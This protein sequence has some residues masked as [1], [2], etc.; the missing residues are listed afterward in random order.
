MVINTVEDSPWLINDAPW[1]VVDA[2]VA[3]HKAPVP[4]RHA[5]SPQRYADRLSAITRRKK[6]LPVWC[7]R[8]MLSRTLRDCAQYSGSVVPVKMKKGKL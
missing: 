7:A 6:Q 1:R 8:D 5:L 3:E 4:F 2:P